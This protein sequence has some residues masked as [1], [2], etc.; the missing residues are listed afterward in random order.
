MDF[1]LIF[2]WGFVLYQLRSVDVVKMQTPKG[3]TWFMLLGVVVHAVMAFTSEVSLDLGF[4]VAHA[5][6]LLE[7]AAWMYVVLKED[8]AGYATT[9]RGRIQSLKNN[10]LETAR[11][12]KSLSDAV[13]PKEL[14]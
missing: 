5:L 7:Y 11:A 3:L 13:K 12:L 14:R 2:V 9:I 8:R 1:V 10:R 4:M 6:K